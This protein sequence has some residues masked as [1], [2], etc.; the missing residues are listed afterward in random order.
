MSEASQSP[1]RSL[2]S[3]LSEKTL[4]RIIDQLSLVEQHGQDGG[5]A[6]RLVSHL[7]MAQ[8]EIGD[9]RIYTGGPL[10]RMVTVRI[11]VP[12]MQLDSHMLFAFMPSTSAIP[13]FTVDSVAAGG[14][15][16]FHLDLI[17]R[18][19]LGSQLAYMDEVFRPLD[20]A[21][22]EGAAIE[23]LSAAQLSRRQLAIMSPWMLAYRASESAFK[24]IDAI[25]QRYLDHWLEV[26]ARGVSDEA[27][28]QVSDAERATRDGLNKAIIFNPDVDPVWRQIGPLIGEDAAL[29]MRQT[30]A[31][32]S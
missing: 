2:P 16:A 11:V 17:P 13:H 19:D 5:P 4:S 3:A 22:A 18:M 7:P 23:G 21:C 32:V 31:E 24:A 26:L 8:G 25:V 9:M 27:L 28:N 14:H 12:A 6:M 20:E 29:K 10:H 30:L 15:F 1:S